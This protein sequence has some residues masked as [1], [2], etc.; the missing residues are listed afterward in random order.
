MEE[1]H[2]ANHVADMPAGISIVADVGNAV[3]RK[4]FRAMARMR[5]RTGVDP[6]I[7]AV[8]DDIVERHVVWSELHQVQL[9]KPDIVQ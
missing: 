7:N 8:R 5:S 2:L 9:L 3:L 4:A 6:G 1:H